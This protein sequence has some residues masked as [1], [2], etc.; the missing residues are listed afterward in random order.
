M[1]HALWDGSKWAK[2]FEKNDWIKFKNLKARYGMHWGE[3]TAG[4][5]KSTG[6]QHRQES[7]LMGDN[8]NLTSRME[9]LAKKYNVYSLL[10]ESYWSKLS[11]DRQV[12]C[13]LVDYVSVKG[14]ET[15]PLK[16]FTI[17]FTKKTP[18][19]LLKYSSGQEL[20]FKGDWEKARSLFIQAEQINPDDG[21]TKHFIN[22]IEESKNYLARAVDHLERRFLGNI[23]DFDKFKKDME[24]SLVREPYSVPR[25]FLDRGSYWQWDEK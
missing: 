1:T 8:V 19:F 25:G 20:Y 7:T 17:D 21:P 4:A 22:R 12:M 11:S 13:R 5:I 2:L 10:T 9:A 24:V 18:D 16:I 23:P 15:Q 6:D 3:V 14:R